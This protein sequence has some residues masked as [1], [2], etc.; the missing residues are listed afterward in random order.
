MSRGNPAVEYLLDQGLRYTSGPQWLAE[1]LLQERWVLA[2][3]GTHGKTTTTSLIAS[4]LAAAPV[5]GSF[6]VS[7]WRPLFLLRYL[8]AF[9]PFV[10]L[11]A[12]RAA[13][14]GDGH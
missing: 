8:V 13:Y 1:H 14:P 3:A 11:L 2:V 7:Q 10:L 6:I 5:L 4:L 9:Q 12:A